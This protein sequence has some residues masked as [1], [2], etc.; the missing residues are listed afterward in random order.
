MS[1]AKGGKKKRRGKNTTNIAIPFCEPMD[2]QYFA[3]AIRPLGSNKVELEVY[4]YNIKNKGSKNESITFDKQLVIGCIRGSMRRRQ[5]VNPG[6]IVLVSKREFS[7]SQNVVDIIL[8]YK[9][10][11]YNQ[12]KKHKLVPLD[13]TQNMTDDAD[14]VNFEVSDP[15]ESDNSDDGIA[16][17][18]Y[19]K[20]VKKRNKNT[21]NEDYMAD[22]GLPM[23]DD[24]DDTNLDID[25]NTKEQDVFG[26]FI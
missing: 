24:D 12:I 19:K 6:C 3:K 11:H 16:S 14:G 13:I 5:Y 21:T 10:D 23:F 18:Q 2:K 22:I 1:A 25:S 7:A 15:E 17:L 8:L 20:T 26:N 9:P 4:F